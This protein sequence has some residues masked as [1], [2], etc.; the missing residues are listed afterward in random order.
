MVP[1]GFVLKTISPEKTL[2]TILRCGKRLHPNKNPHGISQDY[3]RRRTSTAAPYTIHQRSAV[4]R[5]PS[6]QFKK[7]PR[8]VTHAPIEF[9]EK[10]LV[11]A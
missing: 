8:K 3:D 10:F 2:Q 9:C 5:Y 4:Q 11:Y 7:L 1:V 6:I